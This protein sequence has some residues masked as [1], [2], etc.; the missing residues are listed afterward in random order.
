L[1]RSRW[2]VPSNFLPTAHLRDFYVTIPVN[3]AIKPKATIFATIGA[4]SF[5]LAASINGIETGFLIPFVLI[6]E[7][8]TT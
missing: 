8:M 6:V 7:S 3:S 5:S 1:F 4:E 2:R